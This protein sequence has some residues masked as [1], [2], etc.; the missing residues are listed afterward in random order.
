VT[1]FPLISI[2]T[3]CK[4]DLTGLRKTLESIR[5]QRYPNIEHVVVD[6]ASSDGSAELA[7]SYKHI[8]KCISEPDKGLY[9]GMNKGLG[10]CTGEYILFLNSG[11]FLLSADAITEFVVNAKEKDIVSCD[12]T[13]REPD[14]SERIY[15][16]LDIADAF[17]LSDSF[18][19][20][21]AT[22]FRRALFL[23]IGGYD[24]SY[25]FVADFEFY[26][27][28]LTQHGASYSHCTTVLSVFNLDGISSIPEN[29]QAVLMEKIRAFNSHVSRPSRFL[30][31][32]RKKA[33]D[34][35]SKMRKKIY[36]HIVRF[37]HK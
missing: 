19:P 8:T 35:F 27:R 32:I 24:L 1:N 33:G 12:L 15:R 13:L 17:H 14:G 6:A 23:Q 11:D 34:M 10:F 30:I 4:N 18:L 21:P 37:I 31:V 36:K 9:D 5:I 3:V 29:K 2:V 20:H 16:S 7:V 28:A 25:K 22:F 26:L